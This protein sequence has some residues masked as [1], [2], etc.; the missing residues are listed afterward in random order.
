MWMPRHDGRYQFAGPI[1][2]GPKRGQSYSSASPWFVCVIQP[3]FSFQQHS[4][5]A[6][7]EYVEPERHLYHWSY[8]LEA[9]TYV[10]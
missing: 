6:P 1:I 10:R 8:S 9:W 4:P 3:P 5:Q 2:D 7:V